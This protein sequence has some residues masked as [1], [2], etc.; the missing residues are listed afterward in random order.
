MFII[1]AISIRLAYDYPLQTL[2]FINTDHTFGHLLQK[3]TFFSPQKYHAIHYKTIKFLL[4]MGL[5][6]TNSPTVKHNYK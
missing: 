3:T 6:A 1:K 2:F 5:E 4:K